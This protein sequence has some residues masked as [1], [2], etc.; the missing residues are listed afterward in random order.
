VSYLA[1]VL[2]FRNAAVS[3][4]GGSLDCF[5]GAA[6]ILGSEP[7]SPLRIKLIRSPQML[8]TT[9]KSKHMRW[10][11]RQRAGSTRSLCLL[12]FPFLHMCQSRKPDSIT[13][14]LMTPHSMVV[15]WR[16]PLRTTLIRSRTRLTARR[17]VI[18]VS[19]TIHTS[20][21]SHR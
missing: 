14:Y 5:D 3:F 19:P 16:N 1:Y 8:N 18:A 2:R 21:L 6:V 15:P 4:G 7:S 20:C 17:H 13:S 10:H 9:S 12:R 11:P